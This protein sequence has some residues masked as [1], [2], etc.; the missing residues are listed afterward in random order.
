MYVTWLDVATGRVGLT[1][2]PQRQR[3]IFIAS[4]A[5]TPGTVYVG[6]ASTSPENISSHR[7]WGFDAI[8]PVA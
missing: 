8:D 5:E 3:V 7:P 2:Y 6:I 4:F 1:G